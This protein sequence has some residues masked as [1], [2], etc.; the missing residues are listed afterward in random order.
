MRE[1]KF[2]IWN[3]ENKEMLY[4]GTPF[5]NPKLYYLS[6]V[7]G[8]SLKLIFRRGNHGELSRIIKDFRLMQYTGIRDKT[9]KEIY[10]GDI[11]KYWGGTAP[12]VYY[13][14]GFYIKYTG[15]D[16]YSIQYESSSLQVI[17]NIYDNPE[18]IEL[19]EH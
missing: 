19:C 15:E 5:E 2:R 4:L 12:I 8:D 6:D 10:E 13:E 17:G 14:S 7:N 1:I 3:N 18:L 9:G 11:V 16:Y